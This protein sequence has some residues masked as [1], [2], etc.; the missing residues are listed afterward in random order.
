MTP[1]TP[2]RVLALVK[3]GEEVERARGRRE[4]PRRRSTRRRSTA[5]TAARSATPAPSHGEWRARRVADT[6]KKAGGLFVHLGRWSSGTLRSACRRAHRRPCPPRRRSAPTIP[7]RIFCTRPCAKCW[8]TMS[9]RRV[10]SSRPTGCASISPSKAVGA[11]EL[12]RSSDIANAVR[13]PER[14]GDDAADGASTTPSPTGARALFGEKYGDE[15][16]VVS[17]GRPDGEGANRPSRSSSAA[18]PMSARTGDIGLVAVVAESAVAAGVRRIEALTGEA[19]RRHLAEQEPQLQAIA[20]AAQDAGRRTRR[21]ACRGADRGTPPARARARRGA[22]E[23]RAGRRRGGGRAEAETVGGVEASSARAVSGV[24]CAR[25]QE[26]RRR[27]QEAPRLGRR[28]VR[29]R[30]RRRQG[31]LV[32]GVTDDLTPRSAPSILVRAGAEAGR[33]GRRRPPRHGPGRRP[34]RAK[35]DAAIA[36]VKRRSRRLTAAGAEPSSR[37]AVCAG[38][39]TSSSTRRSRP[40]GTRSSTTA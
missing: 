29:R 32:V 23:A 1:R 3:A 16:R 34:R 19:A 18:A 30:R 8:A 36:A 4:R 22:A 39:S 35:A 7:R 40:S 2:K 14:A 9:R 11:D 28:R 24:A 25:P 26:P 12:E 10:R 5:N 37:G 21:R 20:G 27:R 31:R 17:M 15:V 6:Q 33:Q 13:P 38:G